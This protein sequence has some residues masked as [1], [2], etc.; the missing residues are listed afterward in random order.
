MHAVD[1]VISNAPG[2]IDLLDRCSGA[3][4]TINI[5]CNK[6]RVGFGTTTANPSAYNTRSLKSYLSGTLSPTLFT[7]ALDDDSYQVNLMQN[8]V[9][10]GLS[11]CTNCSTSTFNYYATGGHDAFVTNTYLQKDIR[12]FVSSSATGIATF[13]GIATAQ[14]PSQT[15]PNPATNSGSISYR[16]YE[17]GVGAL[18]D[19][20]NIAGSA[21][22]TLVLSNLSSPEDNNR[23]FYL[24]ADYV[25]SGTTPNAINDSLNTS[26]ASLT[27]YPNISIASQP[28]DVTT[29]TNNPGIF[30][31][32]ATT[33]DSSLGALSLSMEI[34]WAKCYKWK[35]F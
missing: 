20:A 30:N 15:P 16:W 27:V 31:I 14:F 1:G 13:I 32:L 28:S 21:T 19:G 2:P 24:N 4:N 26:T 18:V 23:R 8:T 35:R 25:S 5:T 6:I 17:V 12:N 33:T 7:Q 10:V 11:T 34:K 9:Q 22:T 3:Q 29:I